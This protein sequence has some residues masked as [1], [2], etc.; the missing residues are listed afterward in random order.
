MLTAEPLRSAVLTD[1]VVQPGGRRVPS[2]T[3]WWVARH[4]LLGGQH[5]RQLRRPDADDL[6]GLYDAADGP[7]DLLLV[8]GC[9]TGL[10]DVLSDTDGAYDLLDRLG[11][12]ARTCSWSTLRVAYAR[13]ADV[14]GEVD[15]PNLVRVGPDRVVSAEQAVVLDVPYALPLLDNRCAVA[16]GEPVAHL[17]DLPLASEL[18]QGP[19]AGKV[20]AVR[21]W[22]DVPGAQLA[23][24][25]L[26]GTLPTTGLTFRSHLSVDGRPVAWWA[27]R[28][29][30]HVDASA[31]A[32]ATGR[33]LAW[34][35]GRW[36]LRAA[37]VEA[38]Q[39]PSAEGRLRDEDAASAL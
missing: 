4:A 16:G 11:D 8:A 21:S 31:G 6:V 30:D 39:Q 23:A 17:L 26:G 33:A 25:R 37:A 13:L 34:R 10:A 2:Y 3:R 20:V 14:L 38:L 5:P 28:G 32:A 15:P 35:L 1:A 24:E 18:A 36:D 9:R 29:S 12:P 22:A 19:P 27:D 7:D